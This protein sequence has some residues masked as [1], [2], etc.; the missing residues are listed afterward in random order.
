MLEIT[1][2][3]EVILQ[4]VSLQTDNAIISAASHK[5]RQGKSLGLG[6]SMCPG[7]VLL[8]NSLALARW[9]IHTI[10]EWRCVLCGWMV[11]FLD[12]AG[13]ETSGL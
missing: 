13:G 12:L 3:N 11:V 8:G 4:S 6:T 10:A 7:N 9:G 5:T 2:R 1:A